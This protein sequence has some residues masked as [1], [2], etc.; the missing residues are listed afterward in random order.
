MPTLRLA[1]IG[2]AVAAA[3]CS[4]SPTPVDAPTSPATLESPSLP[5]PAE[6]SG[7]TEEPTGNQDA[8]DPQQANALAEHLA[9]VLADAHLEA[10]GGD[11]DFGIATDTV[12]VDQ[13][14]VTIVLAPRDSPTGD[15]TFE[16]ASEE[17]VGSVTVQIGSRS[18]G[19]AAAQILCAEHRYTLFSDDG[20]AVHVAAAAIADAGPCPEH[21]AD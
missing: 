1:I 9:T 14:T 12:A 15:A 18:S 21:T 6:P 10:L 7:P 17:D 19:D 20:D 11:H 4:T 8:A 5:S 2:L 3:A 16:L 13:A